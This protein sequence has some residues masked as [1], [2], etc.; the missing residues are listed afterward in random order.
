[1]INTDGSGRELLARCDGQVCQ[2]ASWS[3]DGSRIAF[4][5]RTLVQ[6]AVGRAPGPARIWL[7][8]MDAREASALF[9]DSQQLGSLPRFAPVGDRLAFYDPQRNTV[10][11]VDPTTADRVELPSLL[12]DSGTWSPDANQ[13]IYPELQAF[14]AGSATQL[15]RA[16]LIT[17]V[18]TAVTPLSATN[19]SFPAW[20]PLGDAVAFGRQFTASGSGL[21]GPQLTLISPDGANMRQLTN[22]LEFNHGAYAW[23]PDGEWIAFQRFNLLEINAQPEI[24]LIKADGSERRKLADDAILPAWL[25]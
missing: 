5:R 13:L 15:L 20:S 3:D 14:D 6:G 12:G 8:D 25:P 10:T 2:A 23:S 19:D 17:N 7:M 16:D 1:L 21:L 4:E 9:A 11:V 18:I 24:W 22:D